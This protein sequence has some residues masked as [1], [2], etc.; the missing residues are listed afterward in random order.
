MNFDMP[1]TQWLIGTVAVILGALVVWANRCSACGKW[2]AFR[3]LSRALKRE[4]YTQAFVEESKN[5]SRRVWK[6]VYKYHYLED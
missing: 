5:S 6:S 3:L 4:G 1:A 2:F